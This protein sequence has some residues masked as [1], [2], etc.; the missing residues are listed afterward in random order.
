VL[1]GIALKVADLELRFTHD[2]EKEGDFLSPHRRNLLQSVL[3]LQMKLI[4]LDTNVSFGIV[5]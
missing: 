2:Q 5:G 4:V 3:S 1:Y